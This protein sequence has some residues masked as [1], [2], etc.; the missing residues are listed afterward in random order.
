M[1]VNQKKEGVPK[2]SFSEP[3]I[4]LLDSNVEGLTKQDHKARCSIWYLVRP[5]PSRTPMVHL[6]GTAV[7]LG[8]PT[9][10]A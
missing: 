5:Q 8:T 3:Q 1:V 2:T 4:T 6:W 10:Q 7:E 9:V